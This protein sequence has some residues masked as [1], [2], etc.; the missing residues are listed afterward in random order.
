MSVI[1]IAGGGYTHSIADLVFQLTR[2]KRD[3]SYPDTPLSSEVDYS[4]VLILLL[5]LMVESYLARV[6]HFDKT[7]DAKTKKWATNYLASLDG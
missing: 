1:S 7:T 2:C 5:V 6:R 4:T 3:A